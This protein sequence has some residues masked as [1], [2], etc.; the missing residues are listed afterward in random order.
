MII[1]EFEGFF[2]GFLPDARI[3]KRA[4]KVMSDIYTFGKAVVNKFCNT[5]IDKI[6]AYRM[7]RNQSYSYEDLFKGLIKSCGDNQ[8]NGHI[9]CLQDTTEF[10]FTNHLE[11]I[12]KDDAD[13]GPVNLNNIAGFFCHPVLAVDAGSGIPIGIPSLK[14]WNRAWDKKDKFE[15][16]YPKLPIEQKEPYRWIDSAI[17]S[18]DVLSEPH[19]LTIIG[20]R[21]A[22]IYEEFSIVPDSRVNL[23]VRACR[24]RN[25]KEKGQ[26][27]YETLDKQQPCT[28]YELEI[29]G[30]KKR[31]NR[32]ARLSLKYTKVKIRKPAKV[33]GDN[34]PDSVELWA[35]EAK[36][37][38]DSVPKGEEPILWRLLTT[39]RISYKDDALS[40]LKWYSKRWLIEEL[41]RILKSKGL[42]IESSQLETGAALKKLVVLSRQVA[43]K[44][45][46]LKLSLATHNNVKVDVLFS[47]QELQFLS[48][49]LLQLEG[50][51][52]KQKIPMKTKLLPG[53]PG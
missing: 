15:R 51:T 9:L 37:L 34:Y 31:K 39:H 32:L 36:E 29:K 25:L 30:N 20:D 53:P 23:L 11:R 43:L 5:N 22:D 6:G 41:F 13:I 10:N 19:T 18:K 17:K 7:F 42:D 12:G 24:N 4:G 50:K 46:T 49:L 33:K 48:I 40:C 21:E 2:D 47:Q 8:S 45:M 44:I 26:K 35:I 28:V 3:E 27:L 14:L 52:R 1:N 16:N 38:T